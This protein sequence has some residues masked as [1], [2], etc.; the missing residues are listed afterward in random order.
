MSVLGRRAPRLVLP[1]GE[2]LLAVARTEDGLL[3]GGSRNALHAGAPGEAPTASLAWERVQAA[4]W[5][6][7]TGELVVAEVGTWGEERVVHR[8]R[9]VDAGRLLQLVRERVTAS[10]VLQRHRKVVGERGVRVVVRRAP[11]GA[12]EPEWFVE[13][14]TGL[15]PADPAVRAAAQDLLA[16]ARGLVGR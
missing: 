5:D 12:G 9:P 6:A 8:W 7:E 4:D 1:R 2:R 15:D 10:V 13:F 3:V 11:S 14:D 16:E